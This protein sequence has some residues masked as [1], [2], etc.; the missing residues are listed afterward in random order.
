MRWWAVFALAGC[1][2]VV[3]AC[4]TIGYYG[5][6]IGGQLDIM[7][8]ERP[9]DDVLTDADTP[10]PLKSRLERVLAMR[11][12]AARELDLPDGDSYRTYADLGR[13]YATWVV[14][15]APE[16]ST[17]PRRWCFLVV[18]CLSY[19][20][21]FSRERAQALAQRLRAE[22]WDVSVS[23][24]RAFSTLGWFDDPVLN[25]MLSEREHYVAGII[26]HELAHQRLYARGDSTFNESYAVAVETAGVRRWLAEHGTPELARDYEVKLRRRAAFVE[27]ITAARAE[28]AAVYASDRSD[29]WKRG[30]KGRVFDELRASHDALKAA[31]GGWSP[32]EAWFAE[33]LNNARLALI[34]TYHEYVPGFE[35][36]LRRHGGDLRAFNVACEELAALDRV[37]RDARMRRLSG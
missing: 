24:A 32:Y 18:G 30:E 2:L 25:T 26:F 13:P 22:N 15:A 5:Q 28:L 35:R 8:R 3:P 21:Y 20:G 17:E 29:D 6:A 33:D 31:W 14:V 10:D 1:A 16:L 9:I 36:L 7:S 11:D 4:A 34:A 12:F 23:G 37:T 19:R 27:M